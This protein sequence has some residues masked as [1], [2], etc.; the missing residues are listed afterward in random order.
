MR[1]YVKSLILCAA[2]TASVSG[3]GGL[4]SSSSKG[5]E[6]LQAG[7]SEYV[8]PGPWDGPVAQKHAGK[9]LFS[10]KPI[11]VDA[12]DDSSIYTEYTLGDPLFIRFYA[13]ESPHNLLPACK[14]PRVIFRSDINGEHKG[15]HSGQ[16]SSFGDI[17][18]SEKLARA[19]GAHTLSGATNTPI[20]TDPATIE[21]KEK[22]EIIE[23]F[24]S[25]V[26]AR[27]HE[28]TNT[29]RIVVDLDCGFT[30]DT[31]PL[32]AEGTLTVM[33]K[34][35][36]VAEY[37]AKYG[38]KL[39]A[40]P[41]HDNAKLVPEIIEVMKAMPDWSNEEIK[42]ASVTS[43]DWIPMRNDLTGVLVK[44]RVDAAVVVR[45]KKETN[46][47]ACRVFDLSFERDVAGGP[48]MFGGVGESKPFPCS[49]APK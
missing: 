17:L 26:I 43:K 24:T 16:M 41:H 42:G 31:N 21:D 28:G 40:S 45:A 29:V 10:S 35:G 48:L 7:D 1:D 34:P 13:K 49:N 18:I 19:R 3:C 38:P 5:N 6:P 20:T 12:T 8:D 2:V 4:M 47:E 27:L 22:A 44:K 25:G 46:P 11:A 9:V 14:E 37:L 39:A 36:A 23:R 15:K 32:Y 33:V 30:K